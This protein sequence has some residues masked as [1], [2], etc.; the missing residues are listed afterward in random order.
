M[1][2]L[3]WYTLSLTKQATSEPRSFEDADEARKT[4]AVQFS[5]VPIHTS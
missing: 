2:R 5:V 4:K 1:I 3:K